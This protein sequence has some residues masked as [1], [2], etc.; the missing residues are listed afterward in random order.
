MLRALLL[1]AVL[2]VSALPAA[3]QKSRDNPGHITPDRATSTCIGSAATP[4][5]AAETLLACLA[6]ADDT[7]CRRVGAQPPARPVGNAG[8][9]QVDYV[10]VRVSVIRPE[11]ITDDT[12]DLDWYKP[13]YTLIEMDRR[14]CPAD[15]PS[16]T[17]TD[18][19][20]LQVYLRRA[21]DG[22][23]PTWDIAAWRSESE[24][25]LAPEI[26]DSFQHPATDTPPE[27]SRP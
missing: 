10:I 16:C 6:R 17:G 14:A 9:I 13:G 22:T 12:R 27:P 11:D 2:C 19:D 3:A 7:L 15:Q 21:G 20:D 24:P 8:K 4:V 1:V 23:A 26:P 25:D 5:C 18:W